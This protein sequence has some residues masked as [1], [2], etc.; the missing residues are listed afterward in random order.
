MTYGD[1]SDVITLNNYLY[2]PTAGPLFSLFSQ[3]RRVEATAVLPNGT[4]INVSWTYETT[5]NGN[6]VYDYAG[7]P[8][9]SYFQHRLQPYNGQ[10][11]KL[12]LRLFN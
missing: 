3:Y 8:N 12:T 1:L 9:T 6:R 11:A 2:I 7:S 10:T 5:N 4:T